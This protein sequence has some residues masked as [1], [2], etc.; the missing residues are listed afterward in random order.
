M[1]SIIER[2]SKIKIFTIVFCARHNKL[3][4]K[5]NSVS[6]INYAFIQFTGETFNWKLVTPFRNKDVQIRIYF[7]LSVE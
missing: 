7:D 4:N 5:N 1:D 3:K 2:L 6:S